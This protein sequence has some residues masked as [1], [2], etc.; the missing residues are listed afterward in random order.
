MRVIAVAQIM[1]VKNCFVLFTKTMIFQYASD[2]KSEPKIG[3]FHVLIIGAIAVVL[4]KGENVI[5]SV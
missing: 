2:L 4:Y 3:K 5:N 1:H